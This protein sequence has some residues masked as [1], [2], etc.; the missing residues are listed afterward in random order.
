MSPTFNV[1][2]CVHAHMLMHA[3]V[4]TSHTTVCESFIISLINSYHYTIYSSEMQDYTAKD[5]DF[6]QKMP[7]RI[8]NLKWSDRVSNN[9]LW[10]MT[11]QLQ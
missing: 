2:A 7:D 10:E 11:E 9:C 1:H 3:R 6:H 4:H 5:T 8:M